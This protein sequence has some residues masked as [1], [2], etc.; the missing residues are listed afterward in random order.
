ML[1]LEGSETISREDMPWREH[2]LSFKGS[3]CNHMFG[4]ET[5]V[6]QEA[7]HTVLTT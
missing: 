5:G 6:V 1:S 4:Q 3:L 2:R 7:P